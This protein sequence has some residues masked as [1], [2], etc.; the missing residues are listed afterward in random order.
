MKKKEKPVA[1]AKSH[2]PKIS[3]GYQPIHIIV[4]G[5]PGAKKSSLAATMPTPILLLNFDP[6][7]KEGPYLR[8]GNASSVE[9][10]DLGVP[11]QDVLSDKGELLIRIEHYHDLDPENPSAWKLFK[12]RMQYFAD[13]AMNWSTIVYDSATYME[14]AAR[15]YDQFKLNKGAKDP[16]QHYNYS[17]M[18]LELHLLGRAA[19]F[20]GNIVVCCHI[21]ETEDEQHGTTIINP[22]APGKLRRYLASGYSE[23]YRAYVKNKKGGES[24][25]L[26]QTESNG[27]YNASSQIRA[28]NPCHPEYEE[29]WDEWKKVNAKL[30]GRS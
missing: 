1:K 21:S 20:P 24:E 22:A 30:R 16:R 4:Y 11:C 18:Q 6:Y 12:T 10:D 3:Y 7:G 26:L 2:Q 28:P 19:A 13:E 14:L 25:W 5:D 15:W 27:Q 17:K 8:R 9:V 29:L 23:L